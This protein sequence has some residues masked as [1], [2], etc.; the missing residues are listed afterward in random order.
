MV[1]K[2]CTRQRLTIV[3]SHFAQIEIGLSKSSSDERENSYL[4]KRK[5][6][7]DHAMDFDCLS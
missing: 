4:L 2:S 5:G 7:K 3:R 6:Q 1:L